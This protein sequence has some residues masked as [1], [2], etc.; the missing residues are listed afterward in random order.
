MITERTK[1]RVYLFVQWYTLYNR[2]DKSGLE[3]FQN[4]PHHA[5]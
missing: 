3:G 5:M 1:I 2:I 4:C